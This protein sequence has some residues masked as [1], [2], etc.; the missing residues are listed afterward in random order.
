MIEVATRE[1]KQNPQRV[2][3]QVL[4]QGPAQITVYGKPSGV[5]LTA[6]PPDSQGNHSDTIA[7]IRR[8]AK[9]YNTT[10]AAILSDLDADRR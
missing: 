1:L 6:Q 5:Y 9:R 8:H 10:R 2:I 7:M 4:E 3:R